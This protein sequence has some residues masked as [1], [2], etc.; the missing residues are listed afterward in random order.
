MW[1]F[2]CGTDCQNMRL[3]VPLLM[4]LKTLWR[5]VWR[6]YTRG[7][8]GKFQARTQKS[9]VGYEAAPDTF[10]VRKKRMQ[11]F[12]EVT[13]TGRQWINLDAQMFGGQ[14]FCS[15]HAELSGASL[16]GCCATRDRVFV[17]VSGSC[18]L[19]SLFVILQQSVY[20]MGDRE[21][22][23]QSGWI[24]PSAEIGRSGSKLLGIFKLFYI[25]PSTMNINFSLPNSQN[26][27]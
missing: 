16:H 4:D 19:V 6:Q 27:A 3:K 5:S 9:F 13:E 26:N 23:E 2:N 15:E 25:Q 12:S 14:H 7:W 18:F 20:S 21:H 24:V 1:W 22:S 11:A 17:S 8:G 10:S